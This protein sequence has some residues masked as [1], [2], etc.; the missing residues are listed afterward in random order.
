MTINLE[1]LPERMK[2]LP[3][4]PVHGPVP[5]FVEWL[6][7]KPEFRLMNPDKLVM[8]LRQKLC[9]VCGGQLGIHKSFVAG[10]MCGINRTS[11]EPP[12][13]YD[14]ALWSA[15]NCPFL[16]NPRQVRREDE[17]VNNAKLAHKSPGF[18]LARNPGV[19]M[20]WNTRHYEIFKPF[21]HGYLIQMGEPESVEWYANGRKATREEVE[22][23]IDTGLPS[24]ELVASKEEGGLAALERAIA[25]FRKTVFPE[26]TK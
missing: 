18:V 26:E 7:G 12:S 6:D 10:P 16:S 11:S 14:C 22:H 17:L 24:L 8:A 23:S 20:L 21:N 15:L 9:W 3:F 2:A 4:D 13:H 25:R 5:W 19:A 1:T